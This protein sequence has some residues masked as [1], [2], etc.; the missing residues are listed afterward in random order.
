VRA[1]G[2]PPD[3]DEGALP[4]G[5]VIGYNLPPIRVTATGLETAT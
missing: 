3:A 5:G 1:G 2:G 4:A